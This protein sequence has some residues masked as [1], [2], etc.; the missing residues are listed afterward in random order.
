[1]PLEVFSLFLSEGIKRFIEALQAT[2]QAT[3]QC[4]IS[5]AWAEA[6]EQ[7]DQL[8]AWL[9][10]LRQDLST[11]GFRAK[12]DVTN[13]QDTVIDYMAEGVMNSE[14]IMII[15][16]LALHASANAGRAEVLSEA[17]LDALN[18]T[19]LVTYEFNNLQKELW[20]ARRQVKLGQA[21]VFLLHTQG[22][23]LCGAMPGN[24]FSLSD[25]LVR[26]V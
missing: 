13:M 2:G 10:G 3:R 24:F 9:K 12:L 23:Q 21:R 8:Q 25:Y 6:G 26:D 16:T 20:Y 22:E 4:F 11:A 17:E 19:Q 14:I 5:Y 1:M 18:E 15:F 7:R